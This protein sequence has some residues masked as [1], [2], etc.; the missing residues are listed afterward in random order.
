MIRKATQNDL[1]KL[2]EFY[3]LLFEQMADYEPYY[4]KATHQDQHFL[5]SVIAEENNFAAFVYDLDKD[6]KGFAIVQMQ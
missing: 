4:R 5:R 1:P 2:E 6:V 3:F